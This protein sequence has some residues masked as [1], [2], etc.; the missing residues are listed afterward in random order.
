MFGAHRDGFGMDLTVTI[1]P[2]RVRRLMRPNCSVRR[3][4]LDWWMLPT[5]NADEMVIITGTTELKTQLM[6]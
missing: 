1:L 4:E 5:G 2:L 6:L 3:R